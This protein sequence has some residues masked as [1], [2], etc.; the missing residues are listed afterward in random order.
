MRLGR[1]IGEGC[2]HAGEFGREVVGEGRGQVDH[3]RLCQ[4]MLEVTAA[5]TGGVGAGN[6]AI[7]RSWQGGRGEERESCSA[8]HAPLLL[9]LLLPVQPSQALCRGCIQIR[10]GLAG[11]VDGPQVLQGIRFGAA[12]SRKGRCVAVRVAIRVVGRGGGR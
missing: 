12:A 7:A 3:G 9:L 11:G 1:S 6:G 2:R 5:E 8:P 4:A 10:A